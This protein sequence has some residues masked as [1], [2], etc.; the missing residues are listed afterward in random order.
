MA[1][2]NTW[3]SLALLPLAHGGD[4]YHYCMVL[5][6]VMLVHGLDLVTAT[7]WS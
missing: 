1:T 2:I 7:A 4:G 6:W 5:V 3:P